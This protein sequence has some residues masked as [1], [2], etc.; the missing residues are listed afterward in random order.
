MDYSIGFEYVEGKK[1]YF[2][3]IPPAGTLVTAS[4]LE[5]PWL[6][7]RSVDEFNAEKHRESVA[8]FELHLTEI[9]MQIRAYFENL[10][11]ITRA[12]LRIKDSEFA[13]GTKID[14]KNNK[15]EISDDEF[16]YAVASKSL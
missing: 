2:A 5:G 9:R 11:D 1:V 16:N 10:E 12:T 14:D 8:E 15:A 6:L 4:E 7:M 3:H 13:S